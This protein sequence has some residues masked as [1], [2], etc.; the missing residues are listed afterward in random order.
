MRTLAKKKAKEWIENIGNRRIQN[1]RS[2]Y[3][4]H[5]YKHVMYSTLQNDN[6]V[7]ILMASL[8]CLFKF[9]LA[10]IMPYR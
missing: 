6:I 1:Y 8:K 9:S 5:V 10:N 7:Y 2:T 4:P 3:S